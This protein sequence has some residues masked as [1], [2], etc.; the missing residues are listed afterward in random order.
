MEGTIED[1]DYDLDIPDDSSPEPQDP[2]I[3]DS[4]GMNQVDDPDFNSEGDDGDDDDFISQVLRSKGISDPNRIN[5]ED[6]NGYLEERSWKDLSNEEKINILNGERDNTNDLSDDEIALINHIRKSKMSVDDYLNFERQQG[7]TQY[8]NSAQEPHFIVDDYS[9][10]EL[11]MLDLQTKVEDIT[12]EELQDALQAAKSNPTLFEKQI[13][14]IRNEYKKL[15]QDRDEREQAILEQEQA[16]KFKSFSDSVINSINS[17]H[18]IGDLDVTIEDDDANELYDFITGTDAAGVNH[19]VKAL[20]D[21]D[22]L[23]RAAWFALY[24]EDVI[25]S[26]SDYYKK[27]ISKISKSNYEKGFNDGK[28]GKQT[29][30]VINPNKNKKI[31]NKVQTIDDLIY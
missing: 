30:V 4:G 13:Q 12:D 23:T 15:E 5:F 20:N 29:S 14:G 9:D 19:F 7:V 26:I 31:N 18:N 6:E 2:Y 25:N 24:G 21:P 3:V 10:D 16:E 27:E 17:F 1:I 8:V 22:V 28:N 11:Y